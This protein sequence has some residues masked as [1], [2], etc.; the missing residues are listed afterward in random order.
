M[1]GPEASQNNSNKKME[2]PQKERAF[3]RQNPITSSGIPTAPGVTSKYIS[4]A[5]RLHA[6]PTLKTYPT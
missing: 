2:V 1:K 6:T 5:K 3:S 4:Y